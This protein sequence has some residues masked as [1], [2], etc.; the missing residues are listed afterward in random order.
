MTFYVCHFKLDLNLKVNKANQINAPHWY[1][2]SL[3][4]AEIVANF[5]KMDHKGE[6]IFSFYLL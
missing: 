4:K 2:T 1:E 6:T 3:S 5:Y